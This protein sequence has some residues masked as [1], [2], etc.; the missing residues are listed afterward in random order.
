MGEEKINNPN[1]DQNR[2]QKNSK[3]STDESVIQNRNQEPKNEKSEEGRAGEDDGGGGLAK[4]VKDM[5][6][7]GISRFLITISSIVLIPFL[8]KYLGAFGYG[9]W[10]QATVTIGLSVLALR[11][12]TPLSIARLFPGKDMSEIGKEL[13]SI[14]VLIVTVVGTFSVL[15]FVFPEPLGNAIFEG[16]FLIVQLVAVIIFIE[17]LD[18]IFLAV[19]QAFRE[20][21][22]IAIINVI[23]KYSEVGLAIILV[24]LGYGIIGA[25]LALLV[26]RGVL[27]LVLFILIKQKIPL[28]KPEFSSLEEHLSIGVPAMPGGISHLLVDMSD[29]YIIGIFLGATYVGYYAPG[30]SLG[31]IV[32][33]FMASVLAYVLL[34]TLSEYHEGGNTSKIRN[35]LNLCTK[36]FLMLAV[37]AIIGI[38]IVGEEILIIFT[39]Q[40][41]AV[42]GYIILVLSSFVGLFVGL[43]SIYKQ[44]VFLEKETKLFT[45]LWGVGA[46]FNLSGNILFIPRFGI[47][48]AGI[49]SILSYLIVTIPI[50]N[51]ARRK[52]LLIINYLAIT[53]ILLSATVMGLLL[54]LIR[55]Q[56]WSNPFFLIIIGTIAYF[57]I[58]YVIRGVDRKEID[59]LKGIY[60]K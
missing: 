53:K 17:C 51:F 16:E 54:Y 4:V 57:S 7:I 38:I 36:Y 23:H 32:P 58:I 1:P 34:P 10:S 22:K 27:S 11:F 55:I 41:I 5:G 52:S 59:Y 42:N 60:G 19:F 28:S 40:E 50:M 13:S 30:Y 31:K 3:S 43:Y 25:I 47:V 12:G 49:T 9:L 18:K 56:V 35:I 2:N 15:L 8:T 45:I 44:T 48:A 46:G 24:L 6:V 37:P 21:K 20:M 39:T 29:R 33:T 26:V 14:L